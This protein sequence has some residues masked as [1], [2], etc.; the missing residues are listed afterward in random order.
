MMISIFNFNTVFINQLGNN[1]WIISLGT[2][3]LYVEQ[4]AKIGSFTYLLWIYILLW[5]NLLIL[6]IVNIGLYIHTN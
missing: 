2:L 6:K 3:M 1:E 5:K 4:T